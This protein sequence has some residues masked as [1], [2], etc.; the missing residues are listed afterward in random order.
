MLAIILAF[1]AGGIFILLLTKFVIPLIR[2][3]KVNVEKRDGQ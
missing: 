3:Y 2:K 1:L